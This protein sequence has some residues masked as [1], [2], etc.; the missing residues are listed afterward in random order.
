MRV[1]ATR[2]ESADMHKRDNQLTPKGF[3]HSLHLL[4]WWAGRITLI[5]GWTSRAEVQQ[6]A[7]WLP[8]Y[9]RCLG[10]GHRMYSGR[11]TR[12]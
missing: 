4:G 5:S 10:K 2:R 7:V 12:V 11:S 9:L 3:G 1:V 8:M 6:D